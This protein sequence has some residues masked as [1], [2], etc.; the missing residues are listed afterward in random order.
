MFSQVNRG[1][2]GEVSNVRLLLQ[3]TCVSASREKK[4]WKIVDYLK[5]S[6]IKG[7]KD[8]VK[9]FKITYIT[10]LCEGNAGKINSIG[11]I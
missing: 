11:L 5:K 6:Y 1:G 8:N 2:K 9:L 7:T 3:V 4:I 10:T